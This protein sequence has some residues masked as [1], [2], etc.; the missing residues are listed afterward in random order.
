M[1][2]STQELSR[3]IEERLQPGADTEAVDRRIQTLFGERWCVVFTDMAGFSRRSARDGIVS[4]LVL[5][6]QMDKICLPIVSEH[7]GFVLKKIADSHMLLF[8]DPR[9]ALRACV[10][11]QRALERHNDQAAEPD[12][13]FMGC[14]IGWGDV[15]KLGDE[16]VF[17][18]EVNFAAKLG[19]DLA[20]PYQILL[21]PAA[22]EAVGK[23]VAGVDL[24]RV[25]GGRLSGGASPFFEAVYARSLERLERGKKTARSLVA[26][27][28]T[29][30]RGRR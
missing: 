27:S 1:G 9:T 10:A 30:R 24:R 2:R 23:R 25:A 11:M 26:G 5:I 17:G 8:R 22:A 29:R 16:E 19:E 21:T 18:V 6:H 15:L 3:L 4:F 12:Q 20:E 7:A 13:L 28:R 14:G